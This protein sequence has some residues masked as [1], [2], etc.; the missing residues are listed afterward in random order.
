MKPNHGHR[1]KSLTLPAVGRQS[2]LYAS[3]EPSPLPPLTVC[4]ETEK[5]FVRRLKP[6]T[7]IFSISC[8]ALRRLTPFFGL[9]LTGMAKIALPR[10]GGLICLVE[11]SPVSKD[12]FHHGNGPASSQ[13][14]EAVSLAECR[15]LTAACPN[16]SWPNQISMV[17]NDNSIVA[18]QVSTVANDDSTGAN[19][20]SMVAK[21][22]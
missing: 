10:I 15:V 3:Y 22:A 4:S 19:D 17:A 13:Q 1:Q 7:T 9:G 5:S 12:G 18:N 16:Q 6:S 14:L 2:A 21:S 11:S 20:P 8:A